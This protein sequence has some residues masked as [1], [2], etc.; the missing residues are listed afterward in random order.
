M[1]FFLE[2]YSA[3]TS[4]AEF[5]LPEEANFSQ[6]E[7]SL[8]E[9]ASSSLSHLGWFFLAPLLLAEVL[10]SILF[11]RNVS[12]TRSKNR[13]IEQK[14]NAVEIVSNIENQ[15]SGLQ[16]SPNFSNI[17]VSAGFFTFLE[18]LRRSLGGKRIKPPFLTQRKKKKR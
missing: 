17:L 16:D 5:F 6:P 2:A 13:Q 11:G 12:R 9:E 15:G 10:V 18:L 4:A 7:E 1:P 14:N 8:P 3:S